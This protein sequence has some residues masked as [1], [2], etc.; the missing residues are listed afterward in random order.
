MCSGKSSVG[1]LL[2]EKLGWEFIDLDEVI[3]REEGMSIPDIF[4][5]KGEDYFRRLELDTL[6]RFAEKDRVVVSTGGGLGANPEAM[7]IMKKKGLVVWLRVSF[8]EF[9][10]RCGNDPSRPMLAL[11]ERKLRVLMKDREK[12]Y[13]KA[14]ISVENKDI[15][16]VVGDILRFISLT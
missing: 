6:K 10:R 11:G 8:E 15:E 1:K 14:H 12:T 5:N 2:S 3:E 9:L 13:A 4:K 7:E 16:S